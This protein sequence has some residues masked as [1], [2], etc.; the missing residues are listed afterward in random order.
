LIREI[1][2]ESLKTFARVASIRDRAEPIKRVKAG[3]RARIAKIR[4]L[5]FLE[6]LDFGVR[7]AE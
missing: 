3:A 4:I 7:H 2:P 5:D 6:P 1:F